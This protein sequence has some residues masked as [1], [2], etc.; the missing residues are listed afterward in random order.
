VTS[1][2]AAAKPRHNR[3][4]RCLPEAASDIDPVRA[5]HL[6]L[7]SR[8]IV[9]A[10]GR[11]VVTVDDGEARL[12]GS[13]GASPAMARHSLTQRSSNPANGCGPTSRLRS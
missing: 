6:A 5:R 7:G 12:P 13:R 8:E 11:I 3:A 10:A 2:S 4:A 9:T 1:P